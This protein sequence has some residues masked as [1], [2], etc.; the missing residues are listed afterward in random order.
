[1]GEELR[2]TNLELIIMAI[3]D[4]VTNALKYHKNNYDV[5]PITVENLIECRDLCNK[6]LEYDYF[7]RSEN[8]LNDH[9]ENN[10]Y[11]SFLGIVDN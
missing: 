7:E 9:S 3:R 10:S 4:I 1:M 2:E 11:K 8:Y 5:E 6:L